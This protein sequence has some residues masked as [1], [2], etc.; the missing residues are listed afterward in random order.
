MK[1]SLANRRIAGCISSQGMPSVGTL[2]DKVKGGLKKHSMGRYHY[3]SVIAVY[4][5]TI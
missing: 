3:G 1:Y 2:A 4:R 5:T